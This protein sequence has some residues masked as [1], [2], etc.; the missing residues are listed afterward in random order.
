MIEILE[1]T[2]TEQFDVVGRWSESD[3]WI[4]GSD[5]LDFPNAGEYD[6]EMMLERFDGPVLFARP[7]EGSAE[8]TV[9]D[10][11][12]EGETSSI[13][14]RA[15]DGL[16]E[17]DDPPWASTLEDREKN[18]Q[19]IGPTQSTLLGVGDDVTE[20]ETE[21]SDEDDEDEEPEGDP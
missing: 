2:G 10:G 19:S 3:G 14:D 4:E 5:R 17:E 13:T 1:R 9:G 15:N 11:V 16:D 6:E 20:V 8:K 18:S 21:G 7:S 12:E